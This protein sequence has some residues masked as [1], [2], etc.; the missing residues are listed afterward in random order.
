MNLGN[1]KRNVQLTII[2]VLILTLITIGVS[3]SAFFYVGGQGTIQT[4]STGTLDVV[5]DS[6]SAA[7]TGAEIMP[8]SIDDLP[9]EAT[10]IADGSY[11]TVNLKNKG[12]VDADFS[13]AITYDELPEGYTTEDLIPLNYLNIGIYNVT[14]NSW[15]NFGTDANP[16]YYSPITGFTPSEENVYPILRNVLPESA[17]V[18]TR[19]YIWLSEETPIK[20]IGKLV[21]LKLD[22]KSTTLQES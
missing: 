13:V 6:T 1:T 7:I 10:S 15:I 8:T 19:V 12:T 16:M 17:E 21:Y 18:Q 11:A 3:Y 5:I 2:G 9:T 4:I 14:S 20:E 22:V